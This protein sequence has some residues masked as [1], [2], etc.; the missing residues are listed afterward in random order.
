MMRKLILCV[1][2]LVL[3]VSFVYAFEMDNLSISL[4]DGKFVVSNLKGEIINHSIDD[5]NY[6]Y[7]LKTP[8]F[9]MDG[10]DG[11]IE[12]E[13]SEGLK[14]FSDKSLGVNAFIKFPFFSQESNTIGLLMGSAGGSGGSSQEVYFINTQTGVF[15]KLQLTDMQE[16]TWIVKNGHPIGFKEYDTSFTFG[17]HAISWGCK[18]RISSVTFFDG[19]GNLTLDR[20]ALNDIWESKYN[21]ITFSAEEKMLL[22]ENIMS[23]MKYRSLGEKLVD[24][25]YYGFKTGKNKEVFEFLNTLNPVYKQ[26]AEYRA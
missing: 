6:E 11:V 2:F 24:F 7:I 23:D 16:M 8:Y 5:L 18:A 21:K 13:K 22:Q 25:V 4:T 14:S 26:E 1:C 10:Y 3:V 17:A 19:E 12:I 20:D 9:K 15:I